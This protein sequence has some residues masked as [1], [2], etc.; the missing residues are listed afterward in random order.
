MIVH[1]LT[2]LVSISHVDCCGPVWSDS[3][4]VQ[5]LQTQEHLKLGNPDGSTIILIRYGEA[6]PSLLEEVK[7]FRDLH[8]IDMLYSHCGLKS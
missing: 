5:E 8:H 6:L 7:Y 2:G 4:S 1:R 3:P